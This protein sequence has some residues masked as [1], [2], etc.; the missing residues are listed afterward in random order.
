MQT[1]PVPYFIPY[2][3]AAEIKQNPLKLGTFLDDVRIYQFGG[4]QTSIAKFFTNDPSIDVG[5]VLLCVPELKIMSVND[6]FES[7]LINHFLYYLLVMLD[8]FTFANAYSLIE[9]GAPYKWISPHKRFS[10]AE[11]M[12]I[13]MLMVKREYDEDDIKIMSPS[14]LSALSAQFECHIP[15]VMNW[16]IGIIGERGVSS[17]AKSVFD[18]SSSNDRAV[19]FESTGKQLDV[20]MYNGRY[21]KIVEALLLHMLNTSTSEE[22]P[23]VRNIIVGHR[24]RFWPYAVYKIALEK[25]SVSPTHTSESSSVTSIEQI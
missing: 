22:L 21:L 8:K 15:M 24:G 14:F 5:V 19:F 18:M 2:P 4:W 6:Q 17:V 10:C 12:D 11:K 25:F 1:Q 23:D 7:F 20:P 16:L 13:L 9:A 3:T